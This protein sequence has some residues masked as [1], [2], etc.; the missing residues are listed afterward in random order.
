M[1]KKLILLLG[2]TVG[3]VNG[4]KGMEGD[5]TGLSEEDQMAMFRAMYGDEAPVVNRVEAGGEEEVRPGDEQF[6]DRLDGGGDVD[7]FDEIDPELRQR[8]LDLALANDRRLREQEERELEQVLAASMRLGDEVVPVMDGGRPEGGELDG[9]LIA[10]S[11]RLAEE[12]ARRL[13]R[14]DLEGALALV[15]A[16]QA[17]ASPLTADDR[18]WIEQASVDNRFDVEQLDGAIRLRATFGANNL[19]NNAFTEEELIVRRAALCEHLIAY[20]ERGLAQ[21]QDQIADIEEKGDDVSEQEV[22]DLRL[23]GLDVRD[24]RA[25]ITELRQAFAQQ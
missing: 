1:E 4:V 13:E 25:T 10:L 2:L 21:T 9:E 20:L 11:R 15:A 7:E 23:F 22:R 5:L 17:D 3:L 8:N 14:E 6:V 19:V 18:R 24:Y 16:L 12:N